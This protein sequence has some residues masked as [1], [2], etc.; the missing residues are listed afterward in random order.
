MK[1][2]NNLQVN[3]WQSFSFLSE[4][5]FGLTGW[6]GERKEEPEP[7]GGMTSPERCRFSGKSLNMVVW[8]KGGISWWPTHTH[9]HTDQATYV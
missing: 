1:A 4:L 8:A 7:R 5:C 9:K 3:K 2:L 6:E